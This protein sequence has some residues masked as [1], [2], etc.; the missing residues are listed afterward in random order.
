MANLRE[1]LDERLW[2]YV[3]PD[4]NSG[5]WL[6]TGAC[7]NTGYG[8]LQHEGKVLLA[9]RISYELYHGGIPDGLDLDH[10]CR[11][12]FCVNPSHL[13]PVTH[14]ENCRRGISPIRSK[15][16]FASI[17]HCPKG[18]EYTEENTYRHLHKSGHTKRQCKEC[19]RIRNV[20]RAKTRK[21]IRAQKRWLQTCL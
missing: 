21:A 2:R 13:E 17:T 8:V 11:V 12:T 6:W 20:T 15:E 9:H 14:Q 16:Y 19:T 4:P 18:H 5:C 7:I 10:K 3:A 1:P